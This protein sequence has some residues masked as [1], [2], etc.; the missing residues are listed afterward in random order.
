M[1]RGGN[2]MVKDRAEKQK[3]ESAFSKRPQSSEQV[4]VTDYNLED[5]CKP[6]DFCEADPIGEYWPRQSL[7]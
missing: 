5:E 6:P 7:S 4:Y 2:E 3:S 1:I